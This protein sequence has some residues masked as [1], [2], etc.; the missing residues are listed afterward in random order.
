[1]EEK[2]GIKVSLGTVICMFIIFILIIALLGMWYYYNNLNQPTEVGKSNI[3]NE[4]KVES[5]NSIVLPSQETTSKENYEEIATEFDGIDCLYVTDVVKENNLYTLKGV[6]YTQYTISKTE[7]DNALKKGFKL[8]GDNFL[9]DEIGTDTDEYGLYKDAAGDFEVY[10]IKKINDDKYYLEAQAQISNVWKLTDR[11][12]EITLDGDI[13]CLY[14]YNYEGEETT[15]QE[16]F[17]NYGKHEARETTNPADGYTFT[18]EFK[19][20]K[21]VKIIDYMTSV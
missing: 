21:C 4:T 12:M 13:P 11:Y 10:R 16:V 20:G 18:F 1:M 8:N 6:V 2:K 3:N 17:D 19:N 14:N 15:V 5:Q 7:L 9:V